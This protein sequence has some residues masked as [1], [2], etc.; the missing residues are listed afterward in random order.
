VHAAR[1]GDQDVSARLRGKQRIDAGGQGMDPAELRCIVN[2]LGRDRVR[3]ADDDGDVGC[4]ASAGA[5]AL[6]TV[7]P[8]TAA[9]SS[10]R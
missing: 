2:Q 1:G 4:V 7:A 5:L 3:L 10:L 8:G 9:T 6:C